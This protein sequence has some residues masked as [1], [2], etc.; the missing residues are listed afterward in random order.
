MDLGDGLG[1]L[2]RKIAQGQADKEAGPAPALALH[3]D[4][5]AVFL[6]DLMRDRQPE[7][8]SVFFGRKKRIEDVLDVFFGNADAGVAH[9]DLDEALRRV[10][11]E[12]T[13]ADL[14]RAGAFDRLNR[15]Q[16]QVHA[17]LFYLFL[18]NEYFGQSGAQ[19]EADFDVFFLRLGL[20]DAG[21]VFDD[22]VGVLGRNV[23]R[24][25]AREVQQ[26][27]H[28]AADAVDFLQREAL[29]Q[30]AELPVQVALGQKLREGPDRD[31]RVPDL[32]RQARRQHA[33]GRQA[34]GAPDDALRLL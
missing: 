19:M 10:I 11:A 20:Q 7:T 29:K 15:V 17:Y 25:R 18:V 30:L 33:Q 34:V 5:P 4:V 6:H 3:V 13:S 8:A 14:H 16:N 27:V 24:G 28:Q 23:G 21:D 9:F 1:L 22:F 2:R 26:I 32:V 12:K 31:Q